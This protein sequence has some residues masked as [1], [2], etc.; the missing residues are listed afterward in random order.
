MITIMK[1]VLKVVMWTALCVLFA[2]LFGYV[3][4]LLWNWLV[5]ALFS[6]P[7]INFWQALGLLVLSKILFGSFGG[8]KHCGCGHRSGGHWKSRYY[9][10]MSGMSPE[11]RERFKA[12]MKEKWCSR[13]RGTSGAESATS[14]D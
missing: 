12:K 9:E 2:L 1:K 13:D 10:K 6:G 7:V 4:M 5:P 3:T 8:G 14:I 11:D